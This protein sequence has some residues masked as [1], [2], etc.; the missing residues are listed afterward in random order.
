MTEP[1]P[2]GRAPVEK[3]PAGSA[4]RSAAY[5]SRRTQQLAEVSTPSPPLPPK[6]PEWSARGPV[7]LGFMAMLVL[8]GGFGL[9]AATA[10][11][12]GAV[13]APGQVEVEQRRQIVQHPDGGVVAE[14]VV[15]EG[16]D[17]SAGQPLIRLDGA[18][19]DTELAIVEGQYFEILAR[20]GRLN[21]E[22][23]DVKDITFPQELTEA[24]AN[25]PELLALMEGQTSLFRARLDTLEQSLGQLAKQ[26]E[27]VQS[28]ID[29]VDAQTVALQQQR[30]FISQELRDQRSLLEKGLAQAPRV[31]AL[32]REAAR[33]DGLL[34]EATSTRAR[35]VTQLA[36]IDL[37]RLEKTATRREAAET[38]LRELGY[39]ELELAERRRSL[40]ERITRLEIRAPVSG[41]VQELQI[42][43]PRSVIR[44]AEPI[45]FIIPQD[46]PLVVAARIAPINI[47]EVHPG[48]EVV[49]RFS[50][51]SSRTTPEIDG[52]LSRV[53]PDTLTDPVTQAPYYRAEVTIAATEVEKLKGL[54]LVPGMPVE[55]YVQTGER[56]PMAYLVKPLSDYFTR[57]FREN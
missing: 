14:I 5:S 30:G 43:T 39:R 13:V 22:R 40:I 3:L 16:E 55:V 25:R 4:K 41:V 33:L 34:G 17:V 31:L 57:A 6:R 52:V 2:L 7:L 27:Q 15:H 42:T 56:S 1:T 12:S 21:A 28:Q 19:L 35:A 51:F 23:A 20:R 32:E 9:W 37:S 8:I 11:I 53:T 18:L 36:E 10:R 50:S 44:P 46:R 49:L 38:E 45:M 29:G 54:E 48:Q 24:A 26:V 47:D